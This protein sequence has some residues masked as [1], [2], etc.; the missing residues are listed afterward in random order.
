MG[1]KELAVTNT[2]GM[3]LREIAA[4][5]TLRETWHRGHVY[6]DLRQVGKRTIFFCTLCQTPCFN[7]SVLND[8][9]NGNL[10][11]RRFAAAKVTLLGPNPWPFSDGVLF[12]NTS[13][14]NNVRG[15]GASPN[16]RGTVPAESNRGN[17]MNDANGFKKSTTGINGHAKACKHNG[18]RH[19]LVIPGVLLKEEIK[20]MRAKFI[21][22][23]HI[24]ARVH[25]NNEG[26][27]NISR[28]WCA[29]LGQGDY[30]DCSELLSSPK[31]D[32]AIVS[33]SYTYELGRKPTS[34]ELEAPGSPGSFFEIDDLGHPR[35]K[36][37]K[38]FSDPEDSVDSRADRLSGCSDDASSPFHDFRLASSRSVRK[39]LRKQKRLTAERTCDICGQ[40]MLLGKDVS[41]LLNCKTGKLACSSRNKNGA[42]HLF[43]TS[44]L[45]HWILLCEFETWNNQSSHLKTRRRGR[46]AKLAQKNCI[47]IFCPECQ[48]TGLHIEGDEMEKPTVPLSEVFLH[49]LKVIESHKTWMKNPEDLK[50]CSTGLHFSSDSSEKLHLEERMMPLKLIHF[51]RADE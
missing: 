9:L 39:E 51:Y 8:H 41:T 18:K 35:K 27:H 28:I 30:S 43:H 12:F 3:N 50:K 10:H 49:K 1:G 48:G 16:V 2:G 40:P 14:E 4:R 21:G 23:G 25:D 37:K 20:D 5:A 6:V 42:F 38:S 46:K 22:Y 45:I 24:G 44:C 32:F 15:T 33:F 31:C 7:D 29:W 34:D 26:R 47:S 17:G 19:Y 36:Q 11:A 13:C